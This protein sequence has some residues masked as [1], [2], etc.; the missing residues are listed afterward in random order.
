MFNLPTEYK[1]LSQEHIL[2]EADKVKIKVDTTKMSFDGI[3][4]SQLEEIV[5]GWKRFI[6]KAFRDASEKVSRRLLSSQRSN[7]SLK[8]LPLAA[9][10]FEIRS[11]AFKVNCGTFF[12]YVKNTFV[13][14]AAALGCL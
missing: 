14:H 9:F 6:T 8:A 11:F 2:D 3:T 7:S 1:A 4:T 5:D 10:P 12:H 13:V